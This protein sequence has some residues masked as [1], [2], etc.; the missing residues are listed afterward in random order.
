M[1]L[2]GI[3]IM[4]TAA[5][6]L[7][8]AILLANAALAGAGGRGLWRPYAKGLQVGI[9]TDRTVAKRGETV[10]LTFLLLNS[11]KKSLRFPG[12]G[13]TTIALFDGTSLIPA[14]GH[15]SDGTFIHELQ[16]NG[17]V[18]YSV[19][20]VWEKPGTYR[21]RLVWSDKLADQFEP[22][23]RM[24]IRDAPRSALRIAMEQ[25]PPEKLPED[26]RKGAF[27]DLSDFSVNTPSLEITVK[28]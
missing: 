26:G 14:P 13:S 16:P 7:S 15:F 21:L 6:Y 23:I 12:P 25:A 1:T 9:A 18:L 10:K 28:E 27:S 24:V 11:D 22:L 19:N 8:L 17:V 4:N 3:R 5:V 2:D 20:H